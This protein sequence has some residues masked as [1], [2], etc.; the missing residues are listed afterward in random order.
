MND[1]AVNADN[2]LV[3]VNDPA[4]NADDLLVNVND[5]AVNAD[6]F[7]GN[8]NDLSVN[9]DNITFCPVLICTGGPFE[10]YSGNYLHFVPAINK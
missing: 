2:L 1:L 8:V 9:A 7:F 10:K 6:D 3:N 5:L 4:V